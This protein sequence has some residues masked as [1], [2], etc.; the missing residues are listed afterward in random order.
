M[1]A[2]LRTATTAIVALAVCGATRASPAGA[3][4]GRRRTAA[5]EPI[6][7]A[8]AASTAAAPSGPVAIVDQRHG[9]QIFNLASR[10]WNR[11]RPWT[12]SHGG[13]TWSNL[14]DV[15]FRSYGG[16]NTLLLTASGGQAA[17]VDYATRRMTWTEFVGGNPHAMELLPTGAVVIAS[18][19]GD[20]LT[21]Y[22]KGQHDRAQT[23]D[24][25]E[26]HAVLWDGARRQLWAAGGALLCAY[27][28]GGSA[29]KP[30]LT[31]ISC[32]VKDL[33]NAH[34]VS[35]MYG[36]AGELWL[37]DDVGVYV[38]NIGRGTRS[39][40]PGSISQKNIKSVGNQPG[41]L[42][43][44]AQVTHENE[45]GTWGNGNVWLYQQ[46]GTYVGNRFRRNAAIYK[47]RPVVWERR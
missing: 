12:W 21:A 38:Y 15:K 9:V 13:R 34:D 5:A 32:P 28:L 39:K 10:N 36:H 7:T 27:R 43:V 2:V 19:T 45:D 41:G 8:V 18:S 3:D 40:A 30:K 16:R 14:S 44:T 6:T 35:P 22:G 37:S 47:A 4:S 20:K 23:I 26:A 24:F 33:K 29:T 1:H 46:N 11:N 25:K 42:I 31:Q 17:T